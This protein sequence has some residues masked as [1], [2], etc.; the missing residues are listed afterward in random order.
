VAHQFGLQ[1]SL[2]AFATVTVQGLIS[3]ADFQSCFQNALL[4][5]VVFYLLGL[6]LGE[7]A[8]RLVEENA[9]IQVAALSSAQAEP[10]PVTPTKPLK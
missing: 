10:R 7:L 9:A 1:L 5:L 4:V 3:G 2:I 8:R 6:V